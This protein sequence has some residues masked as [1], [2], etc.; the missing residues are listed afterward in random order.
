MDKAEYK[1][2]TEH[3]KKLISQGEYAEAS[4]IADTIDWRRVKSV[5]M[6][7][8]VSDLYK[9]NRRYQDAKELLYMAYERN[10][11]SRTIVKIGMEDALRA[12]EAF[13]ILMGDNV[14]S[15]R[16]FIEK[17]AKFAQNLDI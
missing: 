13:S 15:R 4:Y 16:K 3:I 5:M 17:N 14:E 1:I 12:D 7:C 6:L 9:V 11:E 8:T 10:P 2:A